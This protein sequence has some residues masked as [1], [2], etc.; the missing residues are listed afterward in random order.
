MN[1]IY[2]EP[3]IHQT[4]KRNGSLVS[5]RKEKISNGIFRALQSN[6]NEVKI[7]ADNL[8][9]EVVTQLFENGYN[10]SR[11]PSTKDIHDIVQIVLIEN[12]HSDVARDCIKHRFERRRFY[13]SCALK[14]PTLTS[15]H[16][17]I[18]DL[19]HRITSVGNGTFL[20]NTILRK[21]YGE[22]ESMKYL[23]FEPSLI[24]GFKISINPERSV[25]I[26]QM[27]TYQKTFTQ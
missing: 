22:L 11:T 4:W 27:L 3:I 18:L 16:K 6:S 9:S 1:N 23:I 14:E 12:D 21:E 15:T 24:G 20:A 19:I 17:K 7:F 26:N 10:D 5:F 13:R 2:S 8:A 25:Q